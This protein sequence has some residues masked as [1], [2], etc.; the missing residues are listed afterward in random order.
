MDLQN[1]YQLNRL[2]EN[3]QYELNH[4]RVREINRDA[5]Q[6]KELDM[7]FENQKESN[8]IAMIETETKAEIDTIRPKGDVQ[9]QIKRIENKINR[10]NNNFELNKLK[11]QE[12]F[13]L[14]SINLDYQQEINRKKTDTETIRITRELDI[15]SKDHNE[16]N[17]RKLIETEGK[18]KID[19]LEVE[20]NFKKD[21]K[22]IDNK[23]ILDLKEFQLK[24]E[25]MREK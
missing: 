10:D 8:R 22:Q 7:R 15:K 19:T 21:I 20:G 5:C 3:N 25:K 24:E 17:R 4:L 14:D 2:K 11:E 13:K 1:T 18:L 23:H 6:R 12:Q 16:E 9:A